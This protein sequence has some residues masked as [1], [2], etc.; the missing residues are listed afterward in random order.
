MRRTQA[1]TAPL[2]D[3]IQDAIRH[4]DGVHQVVWVAQ[5]Y[6]VG[7]DC[8]ISASRALGFGGDSVLASEVS[9]INSCD[10]LLADVPD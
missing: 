9:E 7:S 2:A 8:C 4:L 10:Q 1:A 6:A 5:W 3:Q